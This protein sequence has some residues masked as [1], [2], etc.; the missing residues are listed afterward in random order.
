MRGNK[1]K[2]ERG[3]KKGKREEELKR[4]GGRKSMC[5]LACNIKSVT[6]CT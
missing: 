5:K 1:R 2:R 3:R 4:R 6:I